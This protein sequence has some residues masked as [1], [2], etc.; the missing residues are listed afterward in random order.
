MADGSALVQ[1]KKDLKHPDPKVR[2]MAVRELIVS[3]EPQKLSILRKLLDEEP[4]I[5]LQYE[6]RKGLNELQKT[7]VD[8]EPSTKQAPDKPKKMGFKEALHSPD[9]ILRLKAFKY[10]EQNR[11]V[12]SLPLL[13]E[14]LRKFGGVEESICVIRLM[15]VHGEKNFRAISGFLKSKDE[16][17]AAEALRALGRIGHIGAYITAIKFYGS[18]KLKLEKVASEVLSGATATQ[19][20]HVFKKA[21]SQGQTPLQLRVLRIARDLKVLESVSMLKSLL[22]SAEEKVRTEAF[23]TFEFFADQGDEASLMILGRGEFQSDSKSIESANVHP[24]L[25]EQSVD[26]KLRLVAELSG[27]PVENVVAVLSDFVRQEKEPRVLASTMSLLGLLKGMENERRAIVSQYVTHKDDRLRANAVEAMIPLVE[28]GGA[29]YF[30]PFL[31]DKNN[32]VIGNAVIALT[33]TAESEDD[34]FEQINHT[35]TQLMRDLRENFNLTSVYCIGILQRDEFLPHLKALLDSRKKSVANKARLTLENWAL[36]NSKAKE[37]LDERQKRK[38][39]FESWTQ[40]LQNKAFNLGG[41]SE[42]KSEVFRYQEYNKI[43]DSLKS[44]DV[45]YQVR[46]TLSSD[47]Q[48]F[49][50]RILSMRSLGQH[51]KAIVLLSKNQGGFPE[52]QRLYLIGRLYFELHQERKALSFFKRSEQAGMNASFLEQERSYIDFRSKMASILDSFIDVKND[53]FMSHVGALIHRGKKTIAIDFLVE[54]QK[55]FPE[56]DSIARVLDK[57][58]PMVF[59]DIYYRYYGYGLLFIQMFLSALILVISLY[60]VQ[61][62]GEPVSQLAKCIVAGVFDTQ[63]ILASLQKILPPIFLVVA[64]TPVIFI[65]SMMLFFRISGR[66]GCYT[67]VYENYVKV[68]DFG[69]VYHLQISDRDQKVFVYADDN[70]YTYISLIRFLPFVPNLTYMYAFDFVRGFYCLVPLYGVADGGLFKKNY[71]HKY[72]KH[73][74]TFNMLGVRGAQLA[75]L[76]NKFNKTVLGV[77]PLVIGAS[78]FFWAYSRFSLQARIETY[79]VVFAA[80]C[81]SVFTWFTYS[82]IYLKAVNLKA[83]RNILSLHVIK[84]GIVFLAFWYFV[85]RYKGFGVLGSMPIFLWTYLFYLIFVLTKYDSYQKQIV[86]EISAFGSE[87]KKNLGK[88]SLR[89]GLNALLIGRER[90]ILPANKILYYN[91]FYLAVPVRFF[92]LTLYYEVIERTSDLIVEIRSRG[93]KRTDIK[94]GNHLVK[95]WSQGS[96]V[97]ELLDDIGL[98]S[99]FSEKLKGVKRTKLPVFRIF[100]TCALLMIWHLSMNLLPPKQYEVAPLTS[101]TEILNKIVQGDLLKLKLETLE[102]QYERMAYVPLNY[103]SSSNQIIFVQQKVLTWGEMENSIVRGLSDQQKNSLA[104]A[105]FIRKDGF[106]DEVIGFSYWHSLL[107]WQPVEFERYGYEFQEYCK[108]FGF[109]VLRQEQSLKCAFSLNLKHLSSLIYSRGEVPNFVNKQ[110][111]IKLLQQD[112]L[113]LQFA[114]W[115]MQSDSEVVF[116]AVNQNGRAL[117]FASKDLKANA[118]L[119]YAAIE[120]DPMAFLYSDEVFKKGEAWKKLWVKADF[121]LS[122]VVDYPKALQMADSNLKM[123]SEFVKKC[124]LANP[125]A[126]E[127]APKMF[128]ENTEF[129]IDLLEQKAEV[130]PHVPKP[131]C[132]DFQFLVSSM[133][134]NAKVYKFLHPKDIFDVKLIKKVSKN[135]PDLISYL[136]K[137]FMS[138]YELMGDL[139]RGNPVCYLFMGLDIRNDLRFLKKHLVDVPDLWV[140]AKDSF[141]YD[142]EIAF[143]TLKHKPELYRQMKNIESR[144]SKEFFK[145]LILD[146]PEVIKFVPESMT[147]NQDFMLSVICVQADALQYESKIVLKEKNF[148]AKAVSCNGGSLGYFPESFRNDKEIVLTAVG[149]RVDSMQYAGNSLKSDSRFLLKAMKAGGAKGWNVFKYAARPLWADKFLIIDA[150]KQSGWVLKYADEVL[151]MDAEVVLTAVIQ[152]GMVLQYAHENLKNNKDIVLAAVSET[153]WAL[154]FVGDKLAKDN[155]ILKTACSTTSIMQACKRFKKLRK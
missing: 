121:V 58:R 83:V 36:V 6:I 57:L 117:K 153:G 74:F 132:N 105:P 147:L 128:K 25:N 41:Q 148:V 106:R 7:A 82:F 99:K 150:V 95:V 97:K 87:L 13:Q 39:G 80:F 154:E 137:W 49:F 131:L 75:T 84:S 62:L 51:N 122:A 134:V 133:T 15:E 140:F 31:K 92:G 27:E 22:E 124:I 4:N 63:V 43:L 126:A 69:M 120:N 9:R 54:L 138:N 56:S 35:L 111:L 109:G 53:E 107:K 112:G 64:L 44:H 143:T 91:Y 108:A 52:P 77:L 123:Q 66:T 110:L 90:A 145:N 42:K 55:R 93:A 20:L 146:N 26:N 11:V 10:A 37:I 127:F 67:E 12:N 14:A 8:S 98:D 94:L 103:N 71:L 89:H 34:Y 65:N 32:R 73:V 29:D 46:K 114:S 85:Q 18:G 136:P 104:V 115:K 2:T 16:L 118:K 149:E 21:L 30:L 151:R 3:D 17:V 125:S 60:H 28:S 47:S 61:Y 68:C 142:K 152:D 24:L 5:Q 116:K 78:L 102:H 139:V 45:L 135:N 100:V 129:W 101:N 19:L 144:F 70:D 33:R 81:G 113:L 79:F 1:L 119:V 38:Q 72:H 50:E 96:A 155:E 59:T 141:Q 86:A 23:K 76:M 48:S 88:L 40:E 130:Y